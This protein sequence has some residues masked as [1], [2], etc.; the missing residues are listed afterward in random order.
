MP[1]SDAGAAVQLRFR[2]DHAAPAN[3]VS[4][5]DRLTPDL[6]ADR[7]ALVAG[8]MAPRASISPKYLYDALGCALFRAICELPEYYPPRAERQIFAMHRADIAHIVGR[9]HQ[10]VDLGAGDCAKGAAWI[11]VLSPSRYVAVDIARVAIEPALWRLADD[12]PAVEFAGVV[13]DFTSGL[14]LR[15]ELGD[16]AV[17]FFYP[18][19]SIGNF[20]PADARAFLT[21]IRLHCVGREGS[22][23]LI[24]VDTR[25]DPARF[26]AAYDDAIG[27]TAA[28]NR[29]VLNHV[30]AVLGSDFAPARFAHRARYDTAAGRVEMHLE[31]IVDQRVNIDGQIRSFAAGET[32]HTE[33]SYKYERTEFV[34]MLHGA[35]FRRVRCWRDESDDFAVYFAS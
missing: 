22:G 24:G 10:F 12:Y 13:T 7:L 31:A 23:L 5:V 18:G 16:H 35:G 15:R 9:R 32:I 29:N 1:T 34:G 17:T 28:F 26:E 30:N 27:L 14:E 11:P 19:S 20:E 21:A 3:R 2:H 4:I 33:S 8:L 25:K 6:E